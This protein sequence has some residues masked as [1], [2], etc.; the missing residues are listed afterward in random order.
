MKNEKIDAY[1]GFTLYNAKDVLSHNLFIVN[2][3]DENIAP[4]AL[5]D[6]AKLRKFKSYLSTANSNPQY[7]KLLDGPFLDFFV[8]TADS[9]KA[10]SDGQTT[11][12]TMLCHL[13]QPNMLSLESFLSNI[14]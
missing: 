10:N 8:N 2:L 12:Q 14:K 13:I 4:E 6:V 5:K 1:N 11:K 7:Q 9:I 3:I